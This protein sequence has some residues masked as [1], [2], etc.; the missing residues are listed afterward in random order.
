MCWTACQVSTCARCCNGQSK[1]LSL[2]LTCL[3]PTAKL[4][5]A[6]SFFKN[7]GSDPTTCCC[8]PHI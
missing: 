5:V 8:K 4:G 6:A 2:T 1:A 3:S 7:Y